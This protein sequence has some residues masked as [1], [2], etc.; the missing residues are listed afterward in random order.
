MIPGGM[1]P[2]ADTGAQNQGVE[3]IREA[4]RL[5]RLGTDETFPWFFLTP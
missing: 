5:E 4:E 1:G 3:M 2:A